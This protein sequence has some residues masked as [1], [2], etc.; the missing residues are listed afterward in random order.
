MKTI[1]D[2]YDW[3]V[4]EEDFGTRSYAELFVKQCFSDTAIHLGDCTNHPVA[5]DLCT[6]EE[7]LKR[8]K[9]YYFKEVNN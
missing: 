4:Q 5:C 1:L 2:L 9:D 3:M 8:Y 7:L 6:M